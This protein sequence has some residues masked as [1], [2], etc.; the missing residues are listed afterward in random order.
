MMISA[1]SSVMPASSAVAAAMMSTVICACIIAVS[2]V[3]SRLYRFAVIVA[4]VA[5]A[6]TVRVCII[7]AQTVI[8]RVCVAMKIADTVTVLIYKIVIAA[9]AV[10]V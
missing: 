6:I 5:D 9:D 3:I 7:V 1:V 10:T 8:I 2:C 4:V